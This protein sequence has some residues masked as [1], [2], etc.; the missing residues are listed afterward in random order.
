MASKTSAALLPE[1]PERTRAAGTARSFAEFDRGIDGWAR[2]LAADVQ[3]V[4][5]RTLGTWSAQGAEAVVQHFRSL[6]DLVDHFAARFDDILDLRSN[7][8]LAQVTTS[9]TDRAG[10]GAY[11]R[12][13]LGVWIFGTDGLITRWEQFDVGREDEA[14]ARF[15]ELTAPR[16]PRRPV[17]ANAATEWLAR[18]NVVLRAGDLETIRTLHTEDLHAVH[19]ATGRVLDREEVLAYWRLFFE[20]GGATPPPEPVA[21]LGDS[22][23]LYRY[24]LTGGSDDGRSEVG[25]FEQDSWGVA[26]VDSDGRATRIEVFAEDHLADAVT[27]IYERDAKLLPE[28]PE[29]SRVAAGAR[30]LAVWSGSIDVDRYKTCVAPSFECVDH[31]LLGTWSQRPRKR[32]LV[33]P[34]AALPCRATG[35]PKA[36]TPGRRSRYSLGQG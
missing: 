2:A 5:H 19:H 8:F 24:V 29:R 20:D 36:L 25:P 15:D 11:E 28:G 17:R 23:A 22:L 4:D 34:N 6:L 3:C 13:F 1:G 12:P 14:L 35:C 9:G 10:D 30:S 33:A 18:A 26:E 32:G 31:R 16:P 21:I 27:L 7:G